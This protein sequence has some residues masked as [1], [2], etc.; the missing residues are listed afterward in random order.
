MGYRLILAP[1]RLRYVFDVVAL[2]ASQPPATPCVV[3]L[4]RYQ[5]HI[6]RSLPERLA[7]SSSSPAWPMCRCRL[8]SKS[9][10][11]ELALVTL[12]CVAASRSRPYKSADYQIWCGHCLTLILC[13]LININ[14]FQNGASLPFRCSTYIFKQHDF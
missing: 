10:T 13:R 5:H 4:S 12:A 8:F 6:L 1:R 14:L 9:S 3:R 2:E 11:A 7:V